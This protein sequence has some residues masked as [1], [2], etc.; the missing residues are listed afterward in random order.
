MFLLDKDYQNER[1]ENRG[2][3]GTPK[4]GDNSK[5]KIIKFAFRNE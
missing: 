2:G 5:Y 3:D 1:E 4:F